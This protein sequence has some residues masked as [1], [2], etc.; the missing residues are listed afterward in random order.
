[1]AHN[2]F[3]SY[4]YADD[5]VRQLSGHY[6]TTARHYVDEIENLLAAEDHISHIPMVTWDYFKD[7]VS[8]MIERAERIKDDYERTNSYKLHLSVNM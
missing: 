8:L 7:N 1:M 3:V 2:V 5:N 6:Y 4:K